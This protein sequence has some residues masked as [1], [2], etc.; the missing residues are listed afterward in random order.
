M[1]RRGQSLNTPHLLSSFNNLINASVRFEPRGADKK[2]Q[3]HMI[4]ATQK[5]HKVLIDN[6]GHHMIMRRSYT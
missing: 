6:D 4:V 5:Q 1:K 2:H 3:I